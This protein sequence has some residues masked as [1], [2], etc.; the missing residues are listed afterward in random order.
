VVAFIIGCDVN[1]IYGRLDMS[2]KCFRV[3]L[4]LAICLGFS[5]MV[6]A[7][8][9][10]Q[11]DF[12]AEQMGAEPS[13]WEYDPGAEDTTVAE[14]IADPIEGDKCLS[15]YGGYVAEDSTEWTDYVVEFDWMF[16]E[17]GRNESVAFRYQDSN[18][19]YQLS[20]R[21]DMQ[22][23]II[24]LYNG[25]WNE[26]GAGIFPVDINIW[27]RVQVDVRGS[28]FVVKMKEKADRS[29]FSDIDPVLEV[30]DNALDKGGFSTSYYGPI[31][32]VIVAES[33]ADILAVEPVSK[34]PITW[35]GIRNQ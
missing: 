32:D 18:N 8:V 10:F 29:L 6:S 34:L 1:S 35:G 13:K 30:S 14:I 9:L 33:E 12:E 2:T 15:H 21:G 31:D 26:L 17:A 20:K 3:V 25:A 23:I 24:Y 4:V 11:D 19:F 22:S 28:D 7:K 5:Q 27:Y 16:T